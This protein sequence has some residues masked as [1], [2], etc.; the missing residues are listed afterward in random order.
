MVYLVDDDMDYRFLAQ[1][2]FK[3][4]LPRYPV[5]LFA[6]RLD[7]I[8]FMEQAVTEKPR[9]AIGTGSEWPALIILDV[10]MPK[11]TGFETLARLQNDP[12]WRAIPVVMMS[13]R[14]DPDVSQTAHHLGAAS[15]L[16]KP[17]GIDSLRTVMEQLCHH[18]EA[19]KVVIKR[20]N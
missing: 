19:I 20:E 7:L 9:S 10:D 2:V 1:Q 3:R 17:I 15:Y 12:Q 5:R 16:P 8:E 18:Y 13:N 4:F 6:D 14:L 11:L